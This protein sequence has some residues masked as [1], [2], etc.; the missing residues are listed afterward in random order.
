M[1][2]ILIYRIKDPVRQNKVIIYFVNDVLY[3]IFN[4]L[5]IGKPKKISQKL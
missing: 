2:Y 3:Y 4:P 1:Y 5:H